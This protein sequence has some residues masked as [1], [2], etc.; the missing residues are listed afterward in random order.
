MAAGPMRARVVFERAATAPDGAGGRSVSWGALW[1]CRGKFTP[2]RGRERL[3]AGRV[4]ASLA[5]VLR[6]RSCVIARDVSEAD[7]VLIDD[8]V[9]QIRSISNPDQRNKYLEM[10]VERGAGT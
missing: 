4:E 8:E 5:G 6:I 10:S 1:A 9:F 3:A 2:E 7:R